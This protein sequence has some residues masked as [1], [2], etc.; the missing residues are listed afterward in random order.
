MDQIHLKHVECIHPRKR[1]FFRQKRGGRDQSSLSLCSSAQVIGHPT[2][3]KGSP[4]GG[5]II[6]LRF[7]Y[8]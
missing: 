4:L 8:L 3:E 2:A 5:G 6:P 1:G 7:C